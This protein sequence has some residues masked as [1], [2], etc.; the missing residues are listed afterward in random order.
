MTTYHIAEWGDDAGD[1]SEAKPFK[2][3]A[4]AVEKVGED[5]WEAKRL[6]TKP[7]PQ[8]EPPHVDYCC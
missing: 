8:P 1:G 3:W 2:T 7:E 5:G 6:T 4:K